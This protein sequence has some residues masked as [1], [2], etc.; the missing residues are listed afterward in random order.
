MLGPD[1]HVRL[2]D[3]G[4]CR[5]INSTVE[6][7][8]PTGSLAYMT[9]ELLTTH[10]GGRHTDWW[11]MG[12][13]AYEL[14]TGRSPWSSSTDSKIMRREIKSMERIQTPKFMSPRASSFI[15]A[16]MEPEYTDRLGT[17]DSKEVCP[18]GS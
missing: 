17:N 8:S 9:P 15:K 10:T 1:G 18:T 14:M 4:L 7:L 13:V 3:F 6:P 11:A 5:E 12:V 16:L 2:V